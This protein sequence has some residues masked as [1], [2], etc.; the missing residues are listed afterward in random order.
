MSCSRIWMMR[1]CVLLLAGFGFTTPSLARGSFDGAWSVVVV[2][3]AGNC[4]P[5]V[6][7]RP[8][9]ME[10]SPVVATAKASVA[11]RVARSGAVQVTVQPGGSR[12]S[13]S[14]HPRHDRRPVVFGEGKAKAAF[15]K[16]HGEAE[17]R[18]YGGQVTERGA[19]TYWLR[20]Q[21]QLWT[22]PAILSPGR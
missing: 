6:G 2:T 10:L 22:V 3:R 16:A 15:V 21:L 19:P 11:G 1:T 7:I 5:T 20:A 13:G 14:G 18:S 12:A 17:R 9:P 8:S 4:P